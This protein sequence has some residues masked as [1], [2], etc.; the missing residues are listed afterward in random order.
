LNGRH[1]LLIGIDRYPRIPD[2]DL[3]GCVSDMELMR[4]LLVDRFGFAAE[5]TQTLRDGQATRDGIRRALADLA[6]V[7]GRDDVVVLFYA[8]HGS[9]M[10]D[11]RRPGR[12]I[13]TLVPHDSGRGVYPNRDIVD[14]EID[15]WVQTVNGT[16]PYVTLIFDC[17]HSGSVTRKELGRT[18][19]EAPPDLRTPE[20]MFGTE[21]PEIFAQTRGAGEAAERGPAGW[22]PGRRRAVV[23]AA[24]RADELACE[25]ESHGALTYFLGEA[26]LQ[27]QPGATWRDVFEQAAPAVT[28]R[29]GSQHPQLE[30]KI[31][32]LLFGTTEARPAGYLEILAVSGT[33]VE[34]SGGAAH[35]VRPG[36]QWTVRSPGARHREAGDE[37]ALLEIE[38]VRA[39]TS[40]ARVVEV[41]EPGR[42]VVGLRIF[43]ARSG[44]SGGIE[45][46]AGDPASRL[47]GRVHLRVL[48]WDLDQKTFAEAVPEP[49]AG[50][51]IFREGDKAEFEIINRHDTAVWVTLIQ[52]G[53]DGKI[54]LLLPRPGHATYARG[55]MR[56]DPGQTV[57]LA[58]DYYLQDPGYAE[59]VRDGLPLHLPEGF[60]WT[61]EPGEVTDF[62]LVTLKLLVTLGS[63]DFEFLEQ[64]GTRS[65][66]ATTAETVP[67]MDW[68]TVS[69]AVGVRR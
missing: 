2:E 40:T 1:A 63:A 37:I 11:P 54:E 21:P 14:E 67:E 5:R 18:T 3:S 52:L 56:L 35:G 65:S 41:S 50:V 66:R 19:R 29:Y 36:S 51:P 49:G 27:A 10:A 32:E 23:V 45:S 26:L 64:E 46:L 31:D 69:V 28:A 16:T 44:P 34:I 39:A 9:R 55:G 12:L 17:C 68:A 43:P 59:A 38:T 62:G 61:G 13:E 7:V 30:G 4:S 6:A 58:G 8:G 25:H 57:R 42:L 33:A 60:P 20:E 47:Q 15:R 48:R 53:C 24:C 22:L